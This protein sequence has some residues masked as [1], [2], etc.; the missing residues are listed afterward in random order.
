MIDVQTILE[1][2]QLPESSAYLLEI[3]PLIEIIWAD[4]KNQ[5]QEVNILKDF[6]VKHLSMLSKDADGLEVVSVEEANQFIDHFLQQRPNKMLIDDLKSLAIERMK[7]RG[8]KEKI[9]SV[10]DYCMDI[11]AACVSAYPYQPS[12][13]VREEEKVLIREIIISLELPDCISA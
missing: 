10:I 13:R 2:N 5:I 7:Q 8:D 12:E 11:A 1:R 9:N 3:I 4:G 6:T